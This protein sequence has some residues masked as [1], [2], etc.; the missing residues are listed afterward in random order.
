MTFTLSHSVT[1]VQV[2]ASLIWVSL[3][4]R[5]LRKFVRRIGNYIW[6]SLTSR[7]RLTPWTAQP[8]GRFE[9]LRIPE[10]MLRVIFSFHDGMNADVVSNGE[11][12]DYF[13]V[14]VQNKVISWP[15]SFS[16]STLSCWNMH[17]QEWKLALKF[18]S[19]QAETFSTTRDSRPK[20]E[21]GPA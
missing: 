8:C 14:T 3:Y 10:N 18:N 4:D 17:L 21:H 7:I 1:F 15:L 9:K 13:P 19:E 12:S 5:L 6:Y 16:L 11:T 2:A 20:L